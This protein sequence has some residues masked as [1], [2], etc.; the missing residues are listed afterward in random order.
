MIKTLEV[1]FPG[2]KRAD[3]IEAGL[4]NV[5]EEAEACAF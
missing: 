2:G 3:A 1:G 5:K 4:L